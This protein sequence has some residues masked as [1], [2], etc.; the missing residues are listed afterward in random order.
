MKYTRDNY[1]D[2][3]NQEFKNLPVDGK[4]INIEVVRQGC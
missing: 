3:K 1:Y 2:L 4:I